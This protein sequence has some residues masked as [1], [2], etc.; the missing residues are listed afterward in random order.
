MKA[1]SQSSFSL[2]YVE[3]NIDTGEL[4]FACT[5]CACH[6]H[7][8][9]AKDTLHT[10]NDDGTVHMCWISITCPGCQ[11]HY[12]RIEAKQHPAPPPQQF[13]PSTPAE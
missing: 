12:P 10:N 1:M 3:L 13:Y 2:K 7:T 5:K 8:G 9:M 4:Q 11:Q 6:L